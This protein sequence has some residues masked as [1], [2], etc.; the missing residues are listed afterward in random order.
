MTCIAIL[1][2]CVNWWSV[3]LLPVLVFCLCLG[4]TSLGFTLDQPDCLLPPF[5][6]DFFKKKKHSRPFEIWFKDLNNKAVVFM[7]FFMWLLELQLWGRLVCQT[8]AN[9][10][11]TQNFKL[12]KLKSQYVLLFLLNCNRVSSLNALCLQAAA[13][14]H[15]SEANH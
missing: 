15:S 5:G 14:A 4:L 6:M 12:N 3:M 1:I 2:R 9:S 13:L 8:C 7:C 11:K 10:K